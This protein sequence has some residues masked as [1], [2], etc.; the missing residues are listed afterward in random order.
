MALCECNQKSFVVAYYG[1][2]S[3]R[4]LLNICID[5]DEDLSLINYAKTLNPDVEKIY[6]FDG[7]ITPS[8]ALLTENIF[9]FNCQHPITNLDEHKAEF[10]STYRAA[11]QRFTS[12]EACI[13]DSSSESDNDDE[14]TDDEGVLNT[15]PDVFQRRRDE[16]WAKRMSELT[17]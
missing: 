3:F 12:C 2:T 9:C 15:Y 13:E 11:F 6:A 8:R 10:H 16:R 7:A 5:H 4:A 1:S 14:S 17:M